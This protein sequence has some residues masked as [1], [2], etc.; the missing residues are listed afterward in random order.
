MSAQI[1]FTLT[2]RTAPDGA[3]RRLRRALKTLLRRDALECID[4]REVHGTP[5][6]CKAPAVRETQARRQEKSKVDMTRYAGRGFIGLDDLAHGPLRGFIAAVEPGSYEKAVIRLTSGPRFS[7][8][9]TNV[10][11]LIRAWGAESSDWV[12]EEIEFY[13]GTVKF[14]GEDQA[15]VLVRPLMRAAGE[16]KK[17]SPKP[18]ESLNDEIPF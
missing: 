4:A 16:K 6:R 9:V 17:S 1:I 18:A 15:S 3:Y 8:N 12:G 2:L 5:H 13:A 7:L 14:K 10:Q 11:T